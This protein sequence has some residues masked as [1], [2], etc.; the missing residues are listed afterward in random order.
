[1]AWKGFPVI[2]ES[3][4]VVM[5]LWSIGSF[6]FSP[7]RVDIDTPIERSQETKGADFD[8]RH[9]GNTVSGMTD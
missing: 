7:R 3:T 8:D 5:M 2:W 6:F 1:M 4:L 9:D